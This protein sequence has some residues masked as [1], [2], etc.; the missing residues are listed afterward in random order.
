MRVFKRTFKNAKGQERKAPKWYIEFRDHAGRQRR[1]AAFTDKAATEGLARRIER[2]VAY[3]VNRQPLDKASVEWLESLPTSLRNRLAGLGLLDKLSKVAAKPLGEHLDDFGTALEAKGNTERHVKLVVSRARR[4]VEACGFDVWSDVSASNVQ[5]HLA[6]LRKGKH[7][8]SA[9]TCNFYL[10]AIKQLGKWMVRDGRASHSPLEHLQGLNVRTDRRHDRRA[11]TIDEQRRLLTAAASGSE[12]QGMAAAERAMLYR[13]AMETGLRAGELRSLTTASFR[14]DDA[15]PTVTVKAAYSKHRREDTLPIRP[16]TVAL[17]KDFFANKVPATPAF[18]VPKRRLVAPMLRA[19][20]RAAGIAYRDNDGRVVDFHALR[21]TF[22]TNLKQAGVHP[23]VAQ[24]LAR[25]STITLTMDHYSHTVVGELTEAVSA[26]P[27]L[28]VSPTGDMEATGTFG[29]DRFHC[30]LHWASESAERG[31]AVAE[32]GTVD[33]QERA[34]SS[35]DRHAPQNPDLR[36]VEGNLAPIGTPADMPDREG[37]GG[38]GGI[39]TPGTQ[40]GHAGFRNRS[41]RP[42]RHLSAR[43]SL[44]SAATYG[45]I[46]SGT[47]A[48]DNCGDNRNAS[49]GACSRAT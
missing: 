43:V 17:L 19:D 27:D 39:R 7:G 32:T 23:K 6:D 16:D 41:D 35:S 8:I 10:Q 22:I 24:I 2:L 48:P 20:L 18:R 42:L 45:I 38:E 44:T 47:E 4:I 1:L 15:P 26:L 36:A 5:R 21:H 3:R 9:Q 31:V 14:L 25:H 30:P 40:K 13:L 11:L 29:K 37:N 34:H 49:R 12:R 33:S 28:S 46:A